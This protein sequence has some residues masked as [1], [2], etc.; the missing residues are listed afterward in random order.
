MYTF[1]HIKTFIRVVELNN[2]SAAARELNLTVAAVSKHVS[3]LENELNVQLMTRTTRKIKLTEVG[4]Q[5]YL[6][7]KNILRA[8][9][10]AEAIITQTQEAPTGQLKVKSERYFA[11]RFIIPKLSGYYQL[12]PDVQIELESAERVPNLIDE[13]FDIVFGRSIQQS[14]NIVQKTITTTHFTICASPGYLQKYGTPTAPRD[15]VNHKYL[16]HAHR[17]PNDQLSF[18]KNDH[19]Y[20]HPHLLINDSDALL[21]CALQDMGF[22]KLQNYVVAEAIRNGQLVVLLTNYKSPAIPISVFYQP[23]TYLQTKVKTFIEYIC[24]GLPETM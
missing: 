9:H 1:T 13:K 23:A 14:E 11:E 22:I 18:G 6:Q 15:L 20:I 24:D 3:Q 17:I 8:I 2:F 7:C 4:H 10:D 19:I 21:H 5:Y 12:Y 16:S